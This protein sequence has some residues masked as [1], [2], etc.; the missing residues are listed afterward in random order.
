MDGLD[1]T[2]LG[3]VGPGMGVI[4]MDGVAMCGLGMD[5]LGMDG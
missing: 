3:I 4:S 1:M 2:R 5:G